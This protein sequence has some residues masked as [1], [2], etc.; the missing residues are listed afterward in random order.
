[1]KKGSSD[2]PLKAS[3]NVS[4]SL[5]ILR[6]LEQ[7]PVEE[8]LVRF[9]ERD[10]YEVYGE[11]AILVANLLYRQ[12]SLTTVGPNNIPF[13]SL[14]NGQFS[15]V[16]KEVVNDHRVEVWSF[17]STR[18]TWKVNIRASPGNLEQIESMLPEDAEIPS[19][20]I[21]SIAIRMVEGEQRVGLATFDTTKFTFTWSS[22]ID[23]E[24]LTNTEAALIQLDVKEC[25]YPQTMDVGSLF[26]SRSI[27]GTEL[28]PTCF[29]PDTVFEDLERLLLKDMMLPAEFPVE[30]QSATGGLLR[31]MNLLASDDNLGV[32]DIKQMGLNQFLRLDETALKAL[33]IFPGPTG[34][35]NSSLLGLLDHCKT[36]QGLKLLSQWIRQPLLKINEINERQEIVQLLVDES[37]Q[38]QTIRDTILRGIPDLSRVGRKLIK[39]RATLQ[40]LV[41][42]YL[43]LGKI[44]PIHE[45]LSSMQKSVALESLLLTPLRYL[46]DTLTKYAELIESTVDFEALNRHEYIVRADFDATLTGIHQ[47]K[48]SILDQIDR[49]F[50]RVARVLGLEKG[51]KVKLEKNSTYGYFCRISRLDGGVLADCGETFQELAALKNGIYFVSPTLRDLS[52]QYDEHGKQY[53]TAQQ[54]L[55]SEMLKVAIT[56]RRVF[57]ELNQII[58]QVDVFQSLAYAAVMSPIPLVRPTMVP[59]GGDLILRQSRHPCVEGSTGSFIP[60]DVHFSRE[61][62]TLQI[63]TGP[64]MGGKSTYIRQTGLISIMAQ[65]G[66]FVPCTEAQIPIFDAVMVRVGAGDS[67]L[68]GM[69]TFMMEMLE[70]SS[71]L[72]SATINSLVIIDELGRGTSTSEG[73]GLAWAISKVIANLGCFTFFATHF[74]ELT[75]L[76]TSIPSVSNLHAGAQMC[77]NNLV[78]TFQIKPG[79]CDQSFGVQVAQMAGFPPTVIDMARILL[80]DLEGV[81]FTEEEAQNALNYIGD[82]DGRF[83]LSN[84]PLCIKNALPSIIGTQ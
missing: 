28:S 59:S 18:R 42:L 34:G 60:N 49:E 69:S 82:G 13:I 21:A 29:S 66:S 65:L 72:R 16:I 40:D 20:I 5:E 62:S 24:L 4:G 54:A 56:Y 70:T 36:K 33:N 80:K 75:A 17:N 32:F 48:E 25:I 2:T 68:R 15:T 79:S 12:S 74:H 78:M 57:E 1:M 26:E 83:D 35:K 61:T 27:I 50:D 39:G 67:I 53:S 14:S 47:H 44:A 63:I 41:L 31:Y 55:V 76:P 19:T 23:S 71:I 73:L 84:A 51:K 7:L 77:G 64:N 10:G 46:S 22:F 52:L 3:T 8:K 58:A 43:A 9:F 45:Q 6:V 38:R 11:S 81:G 30:V 37:I